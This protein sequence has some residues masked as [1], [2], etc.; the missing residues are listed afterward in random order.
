MK[1]HGNTWAATHMLL[2]RDTITML[3]GV[4]SNDYAQVP[5]NALQFPAELVMYHKATRAYWIGH[6]ERCHHF[7]EKLI[8]ENPSGGRH[9][10]KLFMLYYG[11]NSFKIIKRTSSQKLKAVP[12]NVLKALKTDAE[13]S[14]WNFRN[15][16]SIMLSLALP[17][18]SY[19]APM[20]PT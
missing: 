13:H 6:S 5:E 14:K 3:M 18:F 7:C 19:V 10:G 17:V 9:A 11:L 15:K 12:H 20:K 4:N 2:Y 16:V 8:Q 1:S